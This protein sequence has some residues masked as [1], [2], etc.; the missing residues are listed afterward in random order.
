MRG[1]TKQLVG[2]I[3]ILLSFVVA[4]ALMAAEYHGIVKSAGLPIPGASVTA[5][6]GEKRLAT[7]TDEQGAYS[8]PNLED[9]AWTI[10]VEMLGFAKISRQVSIPAAPST[11][12]WNLAMAPLEAPNRQ[13]A[14]R[15]EKSRR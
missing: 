13:A 6:Q 4:R 14:A 5:T 7:T 15:A 3:V 2:R 12:D 9:G 11:S 10:T 1:A 8:F